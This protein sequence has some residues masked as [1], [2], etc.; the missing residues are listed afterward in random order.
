MELFKNNE[1]FREAVYVTLYG[2]EYKLPNGMTYT[3]PRGNVRDRVRILHASSAPR[4]S[5]RLDTRGGLD[6]TEEEK[7]LIDPDSQ[8]RVYGAEGKL[9]IF[10]HYS[11]AGE[12]QTPKKGQKNMGTDF[13]DYL[14]AYRYNIGDKEF[15]Q[16]QLSYVT[17]TCE[18]TAA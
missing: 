9:V 6:L 14:T 11:Q 8:G 5:G 3:D 15:H 17:Q 10:A 12:P 13:R 1:E 16:D 18:L 7:H 4:F 2:P